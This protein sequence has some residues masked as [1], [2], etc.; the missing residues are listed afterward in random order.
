MTGTEKLRLLVIRKTA[1][2]RC[3]G[4]EPPM[5]TVSA[6]GKKK[7]KKKKKKNMLLYVSS[8][9]ASAWI[10]PPPV[11]QT[12]VNPWFRQW[13]TASSGTPID[14]C[15]GRQRFCVNETVVQQCER[16]TNTSS[17]YVQKGDPILCGPSQVCDP[18]VP[19]GCSLVPP[20]VCTTTG[21]F[22]ERPGCKK[23]HSCVVYP[24]RMIH[25][26]VTCPGDL[27]F[28]SRY[29]TCVSPQQSDCNT[30]NALKSFNI[31]ANHI[32]Q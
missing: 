22:R 15:R 25:T 18:T 1:K 31:A 24:N 9:A 3:F 5:H 12:M 2:P 14:M 16:M 6:A 29:N 8:T 19:T 20:F 7:E 10:V 4:C 32:E 23:Y 21:V 30:C 26:V 13:S 27:L 17:R 11:N 28:S